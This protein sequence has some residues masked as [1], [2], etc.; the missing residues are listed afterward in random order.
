MAAGGRGGDPPHGVPAVSPAGAA[1]AP[2]DGIRRCTVRRARVARP[3]SGAAPAYPAA[4]GDAGTRPFGVDAGPG[5]TA[6]ADGTTA[7]P[8]RRTRI[9]LQW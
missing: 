4:A 2:V 8:S 1:G 9:R 3:W 5:R 6:V 7:R